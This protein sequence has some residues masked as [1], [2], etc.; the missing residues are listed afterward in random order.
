MG[1]GV[2]PWLGT[3][4][5]QKL[6]TSGCQKWDLG[7]GLRTKVKKAA[8][9]QVRDNWGEGKRGPRIRSSVLPGEAIEK[10]KTEPRRAGGKSIRKEGVAKLIGRRLP[11][12]DQMIGDCSRRLGK[13]V[14]G[15]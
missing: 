3:G 13:G 5:A 7:L 14:E 11:K 12:K 10:K 6:L 9:P 15:G 4:T 8:T 1:P 2:D